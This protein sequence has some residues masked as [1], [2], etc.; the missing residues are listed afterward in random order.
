MHPSKKAARYRDLK[1]CTTAMITTP[2]IYDTDKYSVSNSVRMT[3]K[4]R[5]HIKDQW[6]FY[7]LIGCWGPERIPES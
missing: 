4:V 6:W 3:Q 1:I 2:N 5:R 7:G